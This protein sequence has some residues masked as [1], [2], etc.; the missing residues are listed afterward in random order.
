MPPREARQI[1]LI[2]PFYNAS[3]DLKLFLES[4]T[5]S[6]LHE[7]VAEIILV[8][9]GSERADP[10]L[11]EDWQRKLSDR[12]QIVLLRNQLRRGRFQARARG[13]EAAQ[14][15]LVLL[16]DVRVVVPEKIA[17]AL[18]AN[19]SKSTHLMGAIRINVSES[20]FNLYWQRSHERLFS[21]N[22]ADQKRG[23]FI[24]VENFENYTKGTGALVCE[25]ATF[26]EI[27]KSFELEPL[28]DD[29]P[30]L[31]AMARRAPIY[32]HDSFSVGWRPRQVL[33]AF[34]HRLWER[35]PS[36]IEYHLFSSRTPLTKYFLAV[37]I[38][39]L[40]GLTV[41]MIEP[42][43]LLAFVAFGIMSVMVSGAWFAHSAREFFL[44]LP[45]HFLVVVVLC[46]AVCR[47]LFVHVART[48]WRR[49]RS[50]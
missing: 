30:V 4:L 18:S 20:I 13:V 39:A 11:L 23:F 42:W 6:D 34:L 37:L 40:I 19:L 29:L 50:A 27:C 17:S 49:H 7:I 31:A 28:S 25:R 43:F 46:A 16:L 21:R 33:T 48:E 35:G 8:D 41:A 5:A 45:L 44:L 9:D 36:M 26:L 15:P 14:C 10:Q 22:F 3:R 24:N 32:V 2:V 1:S 38:S 47:G 12:Y